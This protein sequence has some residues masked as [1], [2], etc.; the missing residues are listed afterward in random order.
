[1]PLMQTSI[2]MAVCS[3]HNPPPSLPPSLPFSL[4]CFLYSN[5]KNLQAVLPFIGPILRL[6]PSFAALLEG[7]LP[8]LALAVF[9]NQL[10]VLL[11]FLAVVEGAQVFVSKEPNE[12]KNERT[13]R[14]GALSSRARTSAPTHTHP[15]THPHP[16]HSP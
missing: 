13:R 2:V 3:T 12:G 9:M 14:R 10:P 6:S 5:L 11:H 15:R 8:S 16:P 1:M 7:F 4:P